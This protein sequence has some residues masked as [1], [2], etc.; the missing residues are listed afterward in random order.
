ELRKAQAADPADADVAFDLGQAIDA[1]GSL[2]RAKDAQAA[3]ANAVRI[4]PTFAAAQ[5]E[6]ATASILVGDLATAE[7]AA[8]DA[9][10]LDGNL[11]AARVAL[12][13]V[14]IAQGR[15]DEALTEGEAAKKLL[16]NASAGEL[17]VADAH[18]GKGDVDLAVESYQKAFGL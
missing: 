12:G 1:K 3:F 2:A 17:V 11:V 9:V 18:A 16:P 4:R 7:R 13:R 8:T 14:R 6:L 15:W 10:K 5:A